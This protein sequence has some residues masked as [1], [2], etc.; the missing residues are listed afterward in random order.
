MLKENETGGEITIKIPVVPIVDLPTIV[1]LCSYRDISY[2]EGKL[3]TLVDATI[4]SMV[5][6]DD[7]MQNKALKD[8]TQSIIREFWVHL[9]LSTDGTLYKKTKY[10]Y[11]LKNKKS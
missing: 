1:K 7:N 10:L 11:Q 2:L 8:V 3:K 6:G 4:P 5:G 9:T